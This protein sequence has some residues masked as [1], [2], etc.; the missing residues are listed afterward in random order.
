MST[1]AIRPSERRV[2]DP[3]DAILRHGFEEAL[4]EFYRS[5]GY[6]IIAWPPKRDLPE[7]GQRVDDIIVSPGLIDRQIQPFR[8]VGS[9]TLLE[10]AEQVESIRRCIGGLRVT[11]VGM[12][13]KSFYKVAE[14]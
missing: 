12:T 3:V 5:H 10:F 9:A 6:L 4:V 2:V 13:Y 1:D 11:S 7:L 14:E 8:I